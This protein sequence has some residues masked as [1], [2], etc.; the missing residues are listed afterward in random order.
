MVAN[1]LRLRHRV[2][3]IALWVVGAVFTIMVAAPA[4]Q[5]FIN[6]VEGW[7]W[8]QNPDGK[9]ATVIAFFASVAASAWFHWTGGALIGFAAGVWMDFLLRRREQRA[10]LDEPGRPNTVEAKSQTLAVLDLRMICVMQMHVD[11]SRLERDHYIEISAV[12]FNATGVKLAASG[13][14][15]RLY[16]AKDAGRPKEEWVPLPEPSLRK[17]G[18]ATE[19]LS[20]ERFIIAIRQYVS[21]DLARRIAADLAEGAAEVRPVMFVL[22]ELQAMVRTE[23]QPELLTVPLWH[24]LTCRL[25][26]GGESM[27]GQVIEA[28]GSTAV[29]AF[30]FGT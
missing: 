12:A 25:A 2:R 7:G 15:G 21:G 1:M 14:F 16:Y 22:E 8:L 13:A 29:R 26:Q 27:A 10:A 28:R 5:F 17:E 6:L 24:K 30:D 20:F 18:L 3:T 4:G 23:Q 9:V 19:Y 11:I